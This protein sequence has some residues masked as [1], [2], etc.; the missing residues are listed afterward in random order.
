MT[1]SSVPPA[2]QRRLAI[3]V[4]LLI[5][6]IGALIRLTA[7]FAYKDAGFDEAVY[8]DYI[9][10]I[11]K[12]GPWEY[13]N[14]CEYYLIGQRDPANEAKL[15]PTRVLY[16]FSGWAA[17][18]LSFGDAPAAD[19]T[20]P[21]AAA[22]DPSFISL[23]RVS[24]L[25]SI[26]VVGLSGIAAWRMVEPRVGLGVMALAA[27]SPLGIHMGKHAFV[28]GFFGFWATLCVW[29]L[30]ENLQ[31]PNQVRWLIAL[32]AAL[33]L[34]VTAKE[35]AIF[36][37]L[38]MCG[39]VGMNHWTKFGT[40]TR[41][42]VLA[43]VLGPLLG[44][45]FLVTLAGGITPFLEIFQLFITKAKTLEFG[46]LHGDGPWFRYLFE[47]I[48]MEPVVTVLA[49]TALVT[50][51][52]K[53]PVFGY[54]LTFTIISYA[55]MCKLRYGMNVRF[56][57]IWAL[58]ITVFAVAQVL[59]FTDRLGRHA[60]VSAIALIGFMSAYSLRQYNVFFV[61]YP[62]YEPIP[63]STLR[64]VDILKPETPI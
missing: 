56:A 48:L 22:R 50:L 51:P 33:A 5:F 38:A 24:M 23:R 11:E 15:P 55:I 8:R 57:T 3:G 1:A 17:K 18:R 41:N 63:I 6:G 42:L 58:P 40:A 35:N 39:I 10:M 45:L 16:I 49:L 27:A 52:R 9:M 20:K 31:R 28:D 29:L 12:V 64:A 30:W 61:D 32:A 53:A 36:V 21:N 7:G 4:A 34:M 47:L 43:G 59:Y 37:Y 60:R 25:F 2:C 44:L 13:P 14:I 19:L 62:I 54:L 26:L 46:I